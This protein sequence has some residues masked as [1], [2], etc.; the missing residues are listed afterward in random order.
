MTRKPR[1]KQLNYSAERKRNIKRRDEMV[2][3]RFDPFSGKG[4][5]T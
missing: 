4:K 5:N 3:E 2:Q 1:A